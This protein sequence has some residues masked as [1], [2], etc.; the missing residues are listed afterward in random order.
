MAQEDAGAGQIAWWA[1]LLPKLVGSVALAIVLV[2]V[3]LSWVGIRALTTSLEA[4]FETKGSAIA[5]SLAAG[6]EQTVSSSISTIQGAID[7]NKVIPGVC[8][9]WIQDVDGSVLV[10]TFSPTFP[11]GFEKVNPLVEEATD[12]GGALSERVLHDVRFDGAACT[13]R[14]AADAAGAAVASKS[15]LRAMDVAV[16]ISGGALGVVHVG[17]D[18]DVIAAQVAG[19]RNR[20]AGFGLVLAVL[21]VALAAFGI[22]LFVTRPIGELTR[23][24]ADI[25]AKGDLTQ[26][27]RVESSDEVGRLASAFQE[28]VKKLRAIPTTLK[29][30]VQDL[31]TAVSALNDVTKSQTTIVQRQASGLAEASATTQEIKQTSAV[32]AGKAEAVGQIAKK[33]EEFSGSGQTAVEASIAGIQDIQQ[34]IESIVTR[35]VD[36]SERTLQVGEIIETVKD[37]ADQS[38]V[39]ALNAAIEAAKAGEFGKG[40]AVVAREIRSLADQSIQSTAR[41]R[42]ILGEIQ[43]AIRSTVAITEEGKRKMEQSMEQI[44]TSGESIREMSLIVRESSQAARQIA[45]SVNQQNAGITQ[46]SAAITALNS[47]MDET[48]VGIRSSETAASNLRGISGRVSALVD[49]FRV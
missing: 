12:E 17:M 6:M 13:S 5:Q 10:H 23:V 11:E 9:I 24:T 21:G 27:I 35:I 31:E 46:I 8:Y 3:V 37:L 41:I 22:N 19:L 47:A 25:V 43:G 39:L 20:M 38:N 49:S 14:T 36:L 40:F 16:P 1:G 2:V 32:A 42:E 28:M 44:R 15:V 29:T 34:Q 7:S 33:A 18:A 26:E 30:S 45:A 4:E 48:V